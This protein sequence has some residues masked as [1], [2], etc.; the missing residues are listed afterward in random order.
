MK[1]VRILLI[2]LTSFLVLAVAFVFVAGWSISRAFEGA[3]HDADINRLGDVFKGRVGSTL[4]S[5]DN[6]SQAQSENNLGAIEY[7]KKNPQQLQKDKAYFETWHSAAAIAVSG[8]D[9]GHHLN[10]WTRSTDVTWV[11]ESNK[12]DFW[13]HAFCIR[14]TESE[15]VV[16]SPGPSAVSSLDCT[17]INLPQ[18][19]IDQM[20]HG[21]LNFHPSGA[22]VLF[23]QR[24]HLSPTAP[25]TVANSSRHR[26]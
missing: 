11:S 19:E 6:H 21:R 10:E 5:G 15:A 17:S 20:S 24:S 18:K 4:A 22:L 16:V 2:A 25:L 14:S 7:Y 8:L 9:T 23:V 26:G 12:K 13:G 1:Y 3:S